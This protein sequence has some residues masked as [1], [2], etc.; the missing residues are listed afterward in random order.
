MVKSAKTRPPLAF[1]ANDQEWSARSI[2]SILSPHGY[3]VLR[4]YN[5][6]QA[7]DGA[8]SAR[9]DLIILDAKLPDLSGIEVCRALCDDPEISP[10]TPILITTAG[11]VKRSQ[12]FE[13]LAAG[14]W[15]YMPLPLDAEELL[16]K[17]DVYMK[18]KFSAD[19]IREEGLVDQATGLYNWRGLMR[20]ARE[21]GSSAYR[22]GRP[23]ACLALAPEVYPG[24]ERRAEKGAA[25]WSAVDRMANVLKT[26]GRVSDAI[27]RVR[28]G[29]FVV[30]AP[31]TDDECALKMA[32]RLTRALEAAEGERAGGPPL[33]TLVGYDAVGNLRTAGIES[34]TLLAGATTALRRSQAEPGGTAIR[35]FDRNHENHSTPDAR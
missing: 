21:L 20:R 24:D 23:L 9:P 17:L 18:A 35:R 19:R 33:K 29:E 32:R 26:Q 27:G 2:E 14:A 4:A 1:I 28:S 8:G 12:R 13:A 3:A 22:Q 15:D 31:D 11:P 5:G 25:N 6:R 10:N 16:L 7:L 30:I 34:A